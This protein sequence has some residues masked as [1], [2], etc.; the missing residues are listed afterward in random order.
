MRYIV[1][2]IETELPAIR[3]GESPEWGIQYAPRFSP[4]AMGIACLCAFD[5]LDDS[6]HV[7][8][9]DNLTDFVDLI[10]EADLLVGF[11]N[12]RFDNQALAS[13]GIHI[14]PARCYDILQEIRTARGG[15]FSGHGLGPMCERNFNTEK[16][17]SGAMAP[18]NWQRGKH[19]TVI[20]Y[21]LHDVHLTRQLFE[22]VFD[23]PLV[24]PVDNSLL[25]LACP[26]G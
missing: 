16:S 7:F 5:S 9:E 13:R 2:D 10:W 19:G 1:Y 24:S 26:G 17:E 11:N 14:E 15:N 3:K 8:L 22:A 4:R 21:C 12:I 18:I 23:G 25:Y 20:N 6:Y